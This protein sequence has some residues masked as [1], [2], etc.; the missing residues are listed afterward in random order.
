MFP[1]EKDSWFM[2]FSN[3]VSGP[4]FVYARLSSGGS[5]FVAT[6]LGKE[7]QSGPKGPEIVW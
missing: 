1:T 7:V 6:I 4:Y 3:E 5:P 2:K